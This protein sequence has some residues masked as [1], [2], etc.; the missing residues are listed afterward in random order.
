MKVKVLVLPH[1]SPSTIDAK[2]V[3]WHIKPGQFINSYDLIV[4]LSTNTLTA[5]DSDAVSHLDIELLEDMYVGKILVE[6]GETLAVGTPI[7]VLCDNLNDITALENISNQS[8]HAYYSTAMSTV[9]TSVSV[10]A[11]WQAYVKSRDD[12]GACG[13]S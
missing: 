7:A 2:I 3:Q 8:I 9:D 12:A 5:V 6:S 11:L 1:L 10:S 4:E 13:C